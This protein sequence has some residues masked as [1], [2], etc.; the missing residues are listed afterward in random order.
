MPN[1]IDLILSDHRMVE[2]LFDRFD[3]TGDATLIG[4]VI[5]QLAGHDD[6]AGNHVRH[7]E[8]SRTTRPSTADVTQS[9]RLPKV[10]RV[11]SRLGA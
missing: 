10:T 4:Q 6:A 7:S 1:G 3:Q 5:D 2:T 8:S 9:A 11:F